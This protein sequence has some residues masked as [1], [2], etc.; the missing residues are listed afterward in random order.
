[1]A[2]DPRARSMNGSRASERPRGHDEAERPVGSRPCRLAR[3]RGLAGLVLLGC[4]LLGGCAP[5]AGLRR[6]DAAGQTLGALMGVSVE[7]MA[8]EDPAALRRCRDDLVRLRL[9]TTA[10][11]LSA[12]AESLRDTLVVAIDA[13][14]EALEVTARGLEKSHAAQTGVDLASGADALR[15]A[16]ID[17]ER[18]EARLAAALA[19]VERFRALRDRMSK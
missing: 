9:E 2:D 13:V 11:G 16:T 5:D 12:G 15:G 6:V 10:L 19:S 3:S 7:A 4:L 8:R 1:M 17:L 18:G 14:V